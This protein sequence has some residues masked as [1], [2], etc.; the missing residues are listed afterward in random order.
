MKGDSSLN[1]TEVSVTVS[2]T[3]MPQDED[4][5]RS[6]KRALI[7]LSLLKP[8]SVPYTSQLHLCTNCGRRV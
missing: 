3:S 6:Q 5:K 4:E 8:A 1:W 2:V 7:A